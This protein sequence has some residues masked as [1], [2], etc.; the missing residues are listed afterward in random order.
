MTIDPN[1]HRIVPASDPERQRRS[2]T[3]PNVAQRSGVTLGNQP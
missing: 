1:L 3:K 2:V